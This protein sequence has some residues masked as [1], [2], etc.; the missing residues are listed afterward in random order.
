M[1]E[2]STSSG[3]NRNVTIG[4]DA[5]YSVGPGVTAM[6]DVLYHRYNDEANV[7]SNENRGSAVIGGLQIAF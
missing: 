2:G 4:G 5:T 6:T 7:K 3:S 1:A